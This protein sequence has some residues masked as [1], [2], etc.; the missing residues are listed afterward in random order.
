MIDSREKL[1]RVP[2]L[3]GLEAPFG[4]DLELVLIIIGDQKLPISGGVP[5]SY[6]T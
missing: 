6:N 3:I 2:F 4:S 1:A 5:L